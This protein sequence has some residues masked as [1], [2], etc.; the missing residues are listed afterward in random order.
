VITCRLP[1]Y[2]GTFAEKYF[3]MVEPNNVT[4]LADTIFR[5]ASQDPAERT[6]M[7]SE[8]RR[9]V[10]Q[11]YDESV[12]ARRLLELYQV[13]VSEAKNLKADGDRL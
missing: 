6:E 13:V 9:A 7:L 4:A 8:A 2:Q 10:V 3:Y 11:E 1:S 5:A 12:S